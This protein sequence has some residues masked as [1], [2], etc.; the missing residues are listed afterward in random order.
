M[1]S[2]ASAAFLF[3]RALALAVVESTAVA[4]LATASFFG[5]LVAAGYANR[6]D[7][8]SEMN[9]SLGTYSAG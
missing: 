2:P 8:A 1:G 5:G 4:T 3:S 7:L 9:S 6:L